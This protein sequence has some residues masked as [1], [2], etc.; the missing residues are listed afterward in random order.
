MIKRVIVLAAGQGYQLDG[1]NK[2]LTKHP[3]TGERIIESYKRLFPNKKITI[4]VGYRSINLMHNYPEFDYVLNPF[5]GQFHNSYSLSLALD[6]ESCYVISGDLFLSDGVIADMEATDRELVVVRQNDNRKTSAVSVASNSD[7]HVT[8]IYDGAVRNASDYESVGIFKVVSGDTLDRWKSSCDTNPHVF[9]GL[10]LPV[11]NGSEF[12]CYMVG[13][14]S[15]F[16]IDEAQD[17]LAYI[18]LC[19]NLDR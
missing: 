19:R 4:V 7:G 11:N 13:E 3:I 2:I 1:F 8:S 15:V 12:E 5:W 6:R 14:N 9:A 10:N 16:E 18:D 17:Y